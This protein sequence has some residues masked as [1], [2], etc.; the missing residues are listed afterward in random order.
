MGT[1]H[2]IATGEFG[3][4]HAEIE[5]KDTLSNFESNFI[6]VVDTSIL[7]QLNT[8]YRLSETK[9]TGRF[10]GEDEDWRAVINQLLRLKTEY[11][12]KL[13]TLQQRYGDTPN[14]PIVNK[15]SQ[16]IQT[17]QRLRI[18]NTIAQK[19]KPVIDIVE[20]LHADCQEIREA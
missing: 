5:I 4:S 12:R 14:L 1:L 3:G 9:R 7:S 13:V 6:V 11:L 19:M 2:S 16:Y 8:I 20:K 18:D 10:P 17:L 15:L